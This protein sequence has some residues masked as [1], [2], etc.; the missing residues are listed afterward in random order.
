VGETQSRRKSRVSLLAALTVLLRKAGAAWLADNAPR[1]GAALAFYTLFSLAPVLIIA[2]SV[3][4]FVF[5]EK[6]AQGEIVRQ[7]QELMGTQ[8]AGAIE[9]MIQVT[10]RPAL[11]VFAATV[12][13]LAI[14]LGA[15]GAFNEL[16]DA[17]NTIWKVDSTTKSF[18][19]VTIRQR[20]FSLG[21]VIVTGFL[22]LASLVVTAV[23]SAAATFARSLI[24]MPVILL[25]CLNFVFSFGMITVLFAVI[26]K[27]IP[28]TTIPWRDVRIGAA[29]TSFLFMVGKVVVGFYLGHSALA[30][31]YGAAASLVIFLIW[32]FYSAQILLFGAELTHVYSLRYGSRRDPFDSVRQ[33]Q[34]MLKKSTAS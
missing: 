28:D 20:F 9:A 4:G 7:F 22:L 34:T 24:P 6:A 15:S 1:L 21:L 11:G 13:I 29:V 14:L 16:Q 27:F 30:S 2:V 32:I 26:L 3:A 17:L 31:A 19:V 10:N 25:E 8:G 12:A 18:W 5:G 23:L 33:A